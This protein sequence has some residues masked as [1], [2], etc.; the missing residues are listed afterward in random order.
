M[1]EVEAKPK[2]EPV[3]PQVEVKSTCSHAGIE[4]EE[5]KRAELDHA[6]SVGDA[7]LEGGE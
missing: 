5:S 3:P 7:P 6:P 2:T 4:R 1:W